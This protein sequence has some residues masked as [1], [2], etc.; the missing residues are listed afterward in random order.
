MKKK[1]KKKAIPAKGKWF[2]K[3]FTYQTTVNETSTILIRKLADYFGEVVSKL[4]RL[5]NKEA[6]TKRFTDITRK[7]AN[8]IQNMFTGTTGDSMIFTFPKSKKK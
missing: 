6:R 1:I 5:K 4:S 2:V 3:K 7:R 8:E